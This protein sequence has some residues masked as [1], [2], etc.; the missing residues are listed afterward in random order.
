M[1]EAEPCAILSGGHEATIYGAVLHPR[2]SQAVTTDAKGHMV[3]WDLDNGEQ[4]CTAE[5]GARVNHLAFD[6][7]GV[8]LYA[9]GSDGVHVWNAR[10]WK[11]LANLEGCEEPISE[12]AIH[13]QG[14]LLAATSASGKVLVW[15]LD[16]GKLRYCL[17][18]PAACSVALHPTRPLLASGSR[19]GVLTLWS[20]QDG[21]V[22]DVSSAHEGKVFALDFSPMGQLASGGADGK[23]CLWRVRSGK[24]L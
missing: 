10:T 8:C 12:L 16:D 23:L 20:L 6:P 21:S 2:R 19:E 5:L 18:G 1:G 13:P 17:K 4:V 9:S 7:Q 11:R 24:G 22:C 14:T 15:N 3:V